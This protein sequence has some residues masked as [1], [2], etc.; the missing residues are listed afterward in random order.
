[1]AA[2]MKYLGAQSIIVDGRVRDLAALGELSVPVWSRGTS[3]IGAGA[4]SKFWAKQVKI[5][6]GEVEIEPGD[7]V[8]VDPSENGVVVVPRRRLDEV[9]GLL[10]GLVQADEKVIADVEGGGSVK[11]AFAKYRT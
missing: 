3:V 4:E 1:M 2:R 7:V 5:K 8:M 9:L 11:E 6:I 10:P